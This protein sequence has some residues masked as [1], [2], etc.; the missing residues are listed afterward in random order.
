MISRA[1]HLDVFDQPA[2]IY[3]F[4]NMFKGGYPAVTWSG[5]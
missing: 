3:F 2:E 5:R 4:N 1:L